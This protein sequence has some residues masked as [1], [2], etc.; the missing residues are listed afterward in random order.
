M[1]V[2]SV[3]VLS[4]FRGII[5]GESEGSVKVLIEFPEEIEME[6]VIGSGIHRD[7]LFGMEL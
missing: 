6:S 7:I 4:E 5:C 2:W 1:M 3:L